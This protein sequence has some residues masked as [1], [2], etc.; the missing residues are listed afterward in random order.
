[1]ILPDVN[2]LVYAFGRDTG[3]HDAY[4]GW[5]RSAAAGETLALS[6]AVLSGFLRIVTNPK[7]LDPPAP[8]HDALEFVRWLIDSP[9][10]HWLRSSP[11]VWEAFAKLAD[12]AFVRGNVVP[13]AYLAALCISH[14]AR[15][16]TADRGFARFERLRWFDPARV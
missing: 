13:D 10:V 6:D 2:V 5:L 3:E 7:I 8:T 4:S 12:D 15:L 16:A 9:R 14:N 11:S 1:M